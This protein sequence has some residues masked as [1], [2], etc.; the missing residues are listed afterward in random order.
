MMNEHCD[1]PSFTDR[2]FLGVFSKLNEC[3]RFFQLFTIAGGWLEITLKYWTL[4][5]NAGDLETMCTYTPVW[6]AGFL[7]TGKY[8][9]QLLVCIKNLMLCTV[10]NRTNMLVPFYIPLYGPSDYSMHKSIA[11]H[12]YS[13][14]AY[15]QDF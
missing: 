8:N 7:C 3:W 6:N 11:H 9:C 2:Q 10:G 14:M 15:V 4:Q 12:F 1:F 13:I 5:Q